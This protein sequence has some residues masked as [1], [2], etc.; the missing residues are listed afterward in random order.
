MTGRWAW[1]VLGCMALATV[2]CSSD[3]D[4]KFGGFKEQTFNYGG[5]ERRYAVY[6]PSNYD[7]KKAY[8]AVLFMH[9][10]FEKGNDGKAPTKVGIG[11]AIKEH[12]E[13]FDAI[14]VFAQTSENWQARGQADLAVATLDDAA[15][16]FNIDP[17]RVV[18]TGLS[19]GGAGV[20][21]AGAAHPGRFAALMPLCGFAE[22]DAVRKLASS[23][24]PVWAFHNNFDFIVL[25]GG[26]K[27]MVEKIN[28]DGGDA[29]M[30]IYNGVGHN[31]W[32]DTYGDKKV[33]QWM[34]AQRR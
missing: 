32:D 34:F 2:G 16:R 13:R 17:R 1:A 27:K 22:Y 14:V 19:N 11:P 24:T 28:R 20:W 23:R 10:L 25:P 9:G 7:P 6:A 8:P 29:K 18:A 3:G 31:C 15:K 12:P 21:L 5:E 33:I 26:T 4:K 30:T